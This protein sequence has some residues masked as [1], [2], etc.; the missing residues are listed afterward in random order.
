MTDF[1]TSS[2]TSDWIQTYSGRQFWPLDPDPEHV[3]IE[4][5]AHALSNLCRYAGHCTTF[6]SVAEHSLLL[7]W[8]LKRDG[9]SGDVLRWALMHDAAEAYIV[10]MPRPIKRQMRQYK[11]IEHLVEAAIALRFDLPLVI[12]EIVQEYDVRICN[13]ERNHLMKPCVAEWGDM[14]A[15]LFLVPLGWKPAHAKDEFLKEFKR[16]FGEAA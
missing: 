14:G 13:D 12:P 11:S 6:Y 7:T 10:D 15:P 8:A 2:G 9:Y 1:Q 3:F 4:D 16:L 5:I